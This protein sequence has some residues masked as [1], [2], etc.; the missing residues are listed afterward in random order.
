METRE[1][2]QRRASY[3]LATTFVILAAG[4]V[5]AGYFYYRN[6]EKHYRAEVELQMSAIAHL[7]VSGLAQW[8]KEQMEDASLFLKNVSFSSLVRRYFEKPD[9]ADARLQIQS[10]VEKFLQSKDQ[11]DGIRLVDDRGVTRLSVPAGLPPFSPTLSMLIPE[12][13]GS[14]RVNFQDFYRD[15]HDRKVY[16][17]CLVPILDETGGGRPLGVIVLRIDP[18]IYLYPYL[19]HWP[20]YSRTAETLLVRRKGSDV[21]FLNELRFQK[22]TALILRISM[23]RRD[24]PSVMAAL[25]REGIVEGRDYRGIPAIAYLSPIPGS[26]WFLVARM[27]LAE[28][29]APWRE[30]LWIIISFVGAL[31][32]GAGAVVALILRQQSVRSYKTRLEAAAALRESHERFLLVCRATHDVVWDWDLHTDALWW[33]EN[34]QSLFGYPIE[35]IEP[36]IKS[37]KNRIHPDDG[38]RVTA[39]IHAAINGGETLW[40]DQYRF[41]RYDGSYAEIYDRGYVQ[42]EANGNAV[43]M[44]GTMQDITERKRVEEKEREMERRLLHA[45]KLESLGVLAGG[46]A[47]DFN[48]LLTAILGN[49]DLALDDLSPVSPARRNIEDAINATK[50]AEALTRQMLAYSGKGRFIIADL[51]LSELVEENAHLLKSALSKSTTLNLRLGRGLPPIS[52]DAGQIQQV[53]M[54]LITNASESLGEQAGIVALSTG[55]LDCDDEAYLIRSRI[56]K[57]PAPGRYVFLDVTD[58]GCG[59]DEETKGR[60]FDPFF[61][62]KFTGRGLGMS[63]VLGIVRGHK[64][65]ITLESEVGKGTTVRVLF[66]V[67]KTAPA[68]R[69]PKEKA[70]KGRMR[71]AGM[72][73]LSGTVLIIDDEEMVRRPCAAMVEHAGYLTLT[74]ASG[75]KAAALL[76]DHADEI[77][78]VILD[79]T[80]PGMDGVATFEA[81]RRIK[82]DVKVILSSGYNEQE[83]TQRFP[84]H[85]LAGF[86]KKPYEM[87]ALLAELGRVA[88]M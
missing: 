18:G 47:H 79:L 60:L 40:S 72:P 35:E 62:T 12:V 67:S 34:F 85:V 80:M 73:P 11:C 74:A 16:L 4:I 45:Q 13:L 75:D 21:L 30:R 8:R 29:Y 37:W 61:T 82:P 88:A 31:L 25:G 53:V 55:V 1:T 26:P 39:G 36:G 51:D 87:A 2:P 3:I 58:T 77:V 54:N 86:I 71:D 6:Y 56:E 15:E 9:D 78:C 48:N 81:L 59:M 33:N 27:D 66:P 38:G 23:E 63:A 57:K 49:M 22:D 5:C 46:I 41:R 83:A 44:I 70:V 84:G 42:R 65:A 14:S 7:K 17:A 43:R 50:R 68:G 24:L 32:V 20:T 19:Q 52:A 64:G 69:G 76:R 28:V 10:W